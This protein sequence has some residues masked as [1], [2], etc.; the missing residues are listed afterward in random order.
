MIHFAVTSAASIITVEAA[1]A[2]FGPAKLE[3]RSL[4]QFPS[5]TAAC[6]CSTVVWTLR[7]DDFFQ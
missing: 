3:D 5:E 6:W 2:C 1:Q 4:L 7:N